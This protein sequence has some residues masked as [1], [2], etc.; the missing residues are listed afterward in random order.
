MSAIIDYRGKS[1][2]K[3]TSGIPLVTAKIVKGGRI[4]EP[5]EFI[6]EADY[7]EWMRR[8]I[9]ELGDVVM[10]TEAPLGE[11]AQ[12]DD[13]RVALAQRLITLRG[14]PE[15]LDNGFL[16]YLLQSEFVQ[17]Q[18]HSRATGTTV[19]GIRQSELRKVGL[20][21]HPL[22]EQR[23]IAAVLGAL[24]D[25]I[26]L[27]RRMN[28]TLE[29]LARALFKAWFVDFEPVRAKMAGRPTGLPAEIDALFPDE[30]EMGEEGVERPRGWRVGRLGDVAENPRRGVQPENIEPDT[31]YIALEHMPRKSITLNDWGTADDLASNKYEFLKGEILFGKLRPYFHKVGVA[32]LDGVCST[33]ILVIQP[34]E[35][36]WFGFVLG[37]VSSVE[38][39]DHTTALSTGTKMPR[40][41]WQD[42]ASYQVIL[43]PT[44]IAAAFT[45]LV[46]D[47]VARI[48]VNI[49]ES[50]TLA[51]LR[52]G[53]LPKLMA[54]EV[55]VNQVEEAIADV[56]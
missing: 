48:Q 39:I 18:L 33:D 20:L 27:N 44:G 28:A 10:T 36:S 45:E 25:K 34:R 46:N 21:L 22:A 1:P 53:L 15:L 30:M 54:G 47:F 16:R 52:D 51:A 37:H 49:E 7:S 8:G 12:L 56:L 5:D 55:R 41:N 50:R 24:D 26:E 29:G 2:T 6:S 31:P 14:K 17:D 43:P 19:F 13:R 3:T 40:T 42:I 11:V 35:D 9:P 38:L 23:A 32:P 4:G